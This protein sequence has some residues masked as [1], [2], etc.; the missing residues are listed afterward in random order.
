[1][2]TLD[3]LSCAHSTFKCRCT[4]SLS[5]TCYS[6]DLRGA[7]YKFDEHHTGRLNRSSF[8]RMLDA[9]M[10][11]VNDDEFDKLCCR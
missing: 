2:C 5:F 8:R 10:C 3:T 7:F 4:N 9:F 1:M 11:F 6:Q